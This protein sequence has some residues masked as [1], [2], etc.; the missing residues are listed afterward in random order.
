MRGLSRERRVTG[1]HH[2]QAIR[3]LRLDRALR[4]GTRL[5]GHRAVLE[6]DEVAL[7]LELLDE[8]A[9]RLGNTGVCAKRLE[10]LQPPTGLASSAEAE[11]DDGD[12]WSL[13]ILMGANPPHV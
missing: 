5:V 12:A 4:G 9:H 6:D 2:I 10:K 3:H 11:Y 7:S 13:R 1:S 8:Y